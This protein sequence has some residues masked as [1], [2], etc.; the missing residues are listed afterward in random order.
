[1]NLENAVSYA[2]VRANLV[3]ALVRNGYSRFNLILENTVPH[4][5]I[6]R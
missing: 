2:L 3:F 1:M 6:K 4:A 5:I